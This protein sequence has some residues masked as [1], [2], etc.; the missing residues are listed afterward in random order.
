MIIYS[1]YVVAGLHLFPEHL[2]TWSF[3]LLQSVII[4]IYFR[5]LQ[6]PA[7]QQW[8]WNWEAC[9]GGRTEAVTSEPLK[10]PSSACCDAFLPIYGAAGAS[11]PLSFFAASFAILSSPFLSSFFF[12]PPLPVFPLSH[13]VSS[14]SNKASGIIAGWGRGQTTA[15]S[16]PQF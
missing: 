11:I 5:F 14:K 3:C 7:R 15:S 9:R 1:S 16:P 6:D 12:L 4:V 8:V 2:L 13:F 10:L